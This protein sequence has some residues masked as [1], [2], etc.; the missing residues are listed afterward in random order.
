MD[1]EIWK[2]SQNWKNSKNSQNF[3]STLSLIPEVPDWSTPHIGVANGTIQCNST[4]TRIG[5]FSPTYLWTDETQKTR[6]SVGSR[7]IP[8][9]TFGGSGWEIIRK[10]QNSKLKIP[11]MHEIPKYP[12][13]PKKSQ[14][15]PSTQSLTPEVP[16]WST[17]HIRVRYGT[18]HSNTTKTRIL[19]GSFTHPW[20]DENWKTRISVG[21]RTMSDHGSGGSG[22]LN[23]PKCLKHPKSCLTSKNMD[24]TPNHA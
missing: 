5:G 2:T 4:K 20:W 21:S 13:I 24:N 7:T 8:N 16:D 15:F 22:W 12:K 23:P 3:R 11:K 6:I 17:P 19:G 10:V 14:N 1:D 9:H 18:I